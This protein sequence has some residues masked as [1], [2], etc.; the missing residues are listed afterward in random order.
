MTTSSWQVERRDRI[1]RAARESLE[2][3]EYEA[4]QMRDVAQRAGVALGTLYRCFSSKEHLYA[5][6]VTDWG[7]RSAFAASGA[8]PETRVR[9]RVHGVITAYERQPQFYRAH[10]TLQ[11]SADPNARELLTEFA[12]DARDA[13]AAEV[14]V[15]G[16]AP[17]DDA[18]TMLWALITSRLTHAIYRGGDVGEIH[19][20]AD[21]F[22]DLLVPRLR[23]EQAGKS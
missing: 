9:A 17:A 16:R 3:Q 11:S 13:L 6:V 12:R 4:I 18:A 15:L 23:D 20:I 22:V 10:V 1:L 8:S 7:S 14:A 2:E 19:R 21:K 5:A